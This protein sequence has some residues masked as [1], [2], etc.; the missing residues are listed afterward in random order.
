MRGSR[1]GLASCP[2]AACAARLRVATPLLL[3]P[4]SPPKGWDFSSRWMADGRHLRTCRTTRVVPADL[5]GWLH[6]VGVAARAVAAA[7]GA[8]IDALQGCDP[9]ACC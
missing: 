7:V 2:A 1:H 6:Q 4:V 5:N 8:G 9:L 3:F